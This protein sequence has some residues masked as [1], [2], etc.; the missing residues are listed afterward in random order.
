MHGIFDLTIIFLEWTI[1]P[2]TQ[3]GGPKR[4]KRPTLQVQK[5]P[6]DPQCTM[7]VES[8]Q[9]STMFQMTKSLIPPEALNTEKVRH[10]LRISCNNSW[11]K[12]KTVCQA[13]D[14]S[15]VTLA[16]VKEMKS[17]VPMIYSECLLTAIHLTIFS[18]TMQERT[19]SVS[20]KKWK[21]EM[22]RNKKIYP[23]MIRS[24]L[25]RSDQFLT[26]PKNKAEFRISRK[27]MAWRSSRWKKNS[28]D[29]QIPSMQ[30]SKLVKMS[31]RLIFSHKV[32][33]SNQTRKVKLTMSD[34]DKALS[35]SWA[36]WIQAN[37]HQES[38]LCETH[39]LESRKKSRIKRIKIPSLMT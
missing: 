25:V 3:S 18:S 11:I 1:F 5:E 35:R 12:T 28:K 26:P 19:F 7:G 27:S 15:V 17:Q 24:K 39:R 21:T 20:R 14:Y 13:M 37:R 10:P 8:P 23:S 16:L 33:I 22:M 36:A 38:K 4:K 30:V 34:W 31:L 32:K 2:A 29:L 9:L 6:R